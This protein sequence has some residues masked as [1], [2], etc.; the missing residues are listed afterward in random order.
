MRGL[1]VP[2]IHLHD[3]S[4][5]LISMDSTSFSENSALLPEVSPIIFR[6]SCRTFHGL[7]AVGIHHPRSSVLPILW[8]SLFRIDTT[9]STIH[10]KLPSSMNRV[11]RIL[12]VTRTVAFVVP[13]I[14]T[15]SLATHW[16]V[17]APTIHR[18]L[19]SHPKV[20]SFDF[21]SASSEGYQR[22]LSRRW[23]TTS[24]T[25]SIV[26]DPLGSM[27]WIQ[28]AVL[29]VMNELF[30]PAEI[31]RGA[32]L[33]KLQKKKKK[34]K[35]SPN[36]VELSDQ[37]KQDI[38]DQAAA[39]ARPFSVDDTMVTVATRAE[40]GDYQVNA[41]MGI[42][43]SMGQNPRACAQQ[44][45]DRLKPILAQCMLE[46][47]IAGPG[48]INL[49]FRPD[50]LTTTATNMAQD[51]AGRLGI[52]P[53]S[54]SQ[55]IVIDYSSPNIAK[56]MH[57]GHLRSTIIGDTLGNVLDFAGHQVVRLN[58]VGDWG[59]QFGMLVEHLRDHYP[60]A[61]HVDTS[62]DV[63]LGDLVELYKKA[64][65]RFDLEPDFRERAREGVVKLQ[66]GNPEE[67]AAW[68]ALC[69]ASR[70]EYQKIYDILNI[71]GLKERGESFYNPFLSEVVQDLEEQGL[72]V[73][74]EGATAVFLEGYENRDGTPLPM[75]VRKSDGGFNYA[76]TDLAAIR[77]RVK[78]PAS[79][80]GEEAD[81]VLYVTDAGQSQHFDMVFAVAKMAGL[82]PDGASLE[83]VPF[84]LVQGEDGKKF[85]TRS[86]DTVK[87]KDL[88]DEAVRIAANDLR[89][90][91]EN[92]D[93]SEEQIERVSKIVGVG[94]VKYADLSMHRQSNYK[95]SYER[96]LSLNGNTAPYMLYAYARVCGI[97][98]KASDQE[99]S[100][101]LAWPETSE[102]II[103]HETERELIRNLVRL[104]DLLDEVEPSDKMEK[105]DQVVKSIDDF[106]T[107]Y[108]AVTQ[109]EQF[110]KLEEKTGY[111]KVYF[112]VGTI[113]ALFILTWAI[114]GFKLITDLLGFV[115]PA[116]MSFQSMEADQGFSEGA[117]Q[118]LTYWVVFSLI[119]V[120]ESIIPGIHK[121]IPLYYYNKAGFIVWLYHPQTNGAELIH[122]KGVRAVI[123]PYLQGKSAPAKKE[124]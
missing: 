51:A 21:F 61:L 10:N 62:R 50:Y 123:L 20:R 47:E 7:V 83:H 58:H 94:A 30:D 28:Q 68:E 64:K 22:S 78:L 54:H 107:K 115:Y 93:T 105:V 69:A 70:V 99:A 39:E 104:P 118:W 116:Y 1:T 73:A 14:H 113:T 33:A 18:E 15:R 86:G 65:K 31:A 77:H 12:L 57:V 66:A 91:E 37:E 40:F 36:G 60:E 56:E 52:P 2:F 97:I 103:T 5:V 41:A 76:T 9:T 8:I 67:V 46:P 119:V 110:K 34:K 81:R 109:L 88:L 84:G 38:A 6:L 102:I 25:S 63:Q 35:K 101:K 92:K 44:I 96:M 26:T 45:A 59:T 95:F 24:S 89:S 120:I 48:F 108:P 42:A 111:S 27:G 85:A 4:T 55:K 100:N 80:G 87:L 90:Y 17:R 23:L 82:V 122:N 117:A 112:F 71:R 98:R 53:A 114:G 124:D 43:K 74:S 3:L 19:V 106:I 121:W 11:A 32:A 29:S 13:R 16:E 72:A 79:A 49:K 75:L